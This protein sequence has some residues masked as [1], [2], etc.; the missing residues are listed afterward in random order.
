MHIAHIIARAEMR[1]CIF[2]LHSA[3]YFLT[4]TICFIFVHIQSLRA[5][6]LRCIAVEFHWYFN[7]FSIPQVLNITSTC[8][9]TIQSYTR[10]FGYIN[11]LQ[12]CTKKRKS[13]WGLKSNQQRK[14]PGRWANFLIKRTSSLL[15]NKETSM[16]AIADRVYS[17]PVAEVTSSKLVL[18]LNSIKYRP[19]RTW[20]RHTPAQRGR[21]NQQHIIMH[22]IRFDWNGWFII[23]I[24]IGRRIYSALWH[25]FYTSSV[26]YVYCME[27]QNTTLNSQATEEKI[28]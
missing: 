12:W 18:I 15:V 8:V 7:C 26:Y 21:W 10:G 27:M 4:C 17:K 14:S 24:L 28:V 5:F 1:K 6:H 23:A 19:P 13:L 3:A 11:L 25:T 2:S 20:N 9:H 16:I 22:F